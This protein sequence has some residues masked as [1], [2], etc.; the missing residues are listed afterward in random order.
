MS[1]RIHYTVAEKASF[2]IVPETCPAIEK[3]LD[4]A[5]RHSGFSDEAVNDVLAKYN[6][7]PI[8]GLRHALDELV[9]RLLFGKKRELSDVVLY[10]GTFPL[11]AALVKQIEVA[12]G[13]EPDRNHFAE[14]IAM[15]PR[16]RTD[17]ALGEAS[18]G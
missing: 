13:M 7:Q 12:R 3:A 18:H 16:N 5:F 15:R 10:E 6:I 1:V 17:A 4:A 14:W 11:R 2:A 8:K 9:G